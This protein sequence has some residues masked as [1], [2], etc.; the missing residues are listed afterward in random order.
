MNIEARYIMY[1]ELKYYNYKLN[2]MTILAIMHD[3]IYSIDL[4]PV[5]V[6]VSSE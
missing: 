4:L 6:Q 3:P 5:E 1:G 2:C